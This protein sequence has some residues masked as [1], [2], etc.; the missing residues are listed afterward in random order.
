VDNLKDVKGYED[1]YYVDDNGVIFSKRF[2]KPLKPFKSKV[3]YLYVDLFDG[4]SKKR[5]AVH[6]VVAECYHGTPKKELDVNHK[7]R[8]R[9][10]NHPSNLEWVTRSENLI[11]ARGRKVAKLDKDTLEVLKVYDAIVYAEADGFKTPEIVN[12]CKGNLN[13]HYGFKWKYLD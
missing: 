2:K 9:L 8:N 3:G 7:D 10:N 6:R 12:C 1:F 4:K 11:H 5:H 13:Y